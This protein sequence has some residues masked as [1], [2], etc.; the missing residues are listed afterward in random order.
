MDSKPG[1]M[2]KQ[3]AFVTIENQ[4]NITYYQRLAYGR[5]PGNSSHHKSVKLIL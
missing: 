2:D 1:G 3:A 4:I 5:Q